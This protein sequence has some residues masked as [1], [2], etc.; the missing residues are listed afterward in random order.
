MTNDDGGKLEKAVAS[1][2]IK[3]SL[4]PQTS[5]VYIASLRLWE[6]N[7]S[8]AID[9][10]PREDQSDWSALQIYNQETARGEEREGMVNS[11]SLYR[12]FHDFRT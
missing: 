6:G 8:E 5:A 4:C 2:Q 10:I 7:V 3:V 1:L 9:N 12:V 11:D